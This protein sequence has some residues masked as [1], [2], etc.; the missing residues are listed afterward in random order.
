MG[1]AAYDDY[2]GSTVVQFDFDKDGLPDFYS[3]ESTEQEQ[4]ALAVALDDDIDG[5]GIAN[6][7]DATPY[8]AVCEL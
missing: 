2:P 6:A 1:Y 5:D 8:C 7:S 4:G 3:P